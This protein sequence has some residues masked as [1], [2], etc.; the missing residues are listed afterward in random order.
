MHLTRSTGHSE[1][2]GLI[3]GTLL[4]LLV[5]AC[6]RPIKDLPVYYDKAP[7]KNND[8]L[9]VGF[10]GVGCFLIQRG[11]DA[12]LTDP[13]VSNPSSGKVVFGKIRIDTA[14]V[15]QYIPETQNIRMV[16][17]GHS[18]Y[19]HLLDLPYIASRLNDDVSV[20]GNETM[21]HTMAPYHL[22]QPLESMNNKTGNIDRK[23][24]WTYSV[25]SSIRIMPF[26]SKHP[27]HMLGI[28]LYKGPLNND[29]EKT[30]LKA[31]KWK[32]GLTLSYLIDFMNKTHKGTVDYR[33]FF[34]SSPADQPMGFYPVEMNDEKKVDIAIL[35][36]GAVK[37]VDTYPKEILEQTNPAVLVLA[38]WEN[39]F[40]P[41]DAPL[42]QVSR[43]D[44]PKFL[45]Y[46]QP[47]FPGDR[48]FYLPAPG[49]SF[50]YRH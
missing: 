1:I 38:H 46:L 41:K 39:F 25:D 33:I 29:L 17:I 48:P 49:S 43:G 24:Q 10:I 42:K 20:C 16:I 44:I 6:S 18:H 36:A 30:P 47:L 13:F 40:R 12:I 5:A 45:Q 27:P 9:H 15:N 14:I 35:S 2:Y 50:S 11:E 23:G 37:S 32:S 8:E 19:D 28:E 34:Q 22:K 26:V 4:L 7:I 31:K 21:L 3:T